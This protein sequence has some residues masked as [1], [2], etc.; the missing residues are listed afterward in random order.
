MLRVRSHRSDCARSLGASERTPAQ[1]TTRRR[2]AHPMRKTPTTAMRCPWRITE[3]PPSLY[4]RLLLRT[5]RSMPHDEARRISTE[6]YSPKCLEGE[7][8][9]VREQV[10]LLNPFLMSTIKEGTTLR[11]AP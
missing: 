6:A 9:E 5:P 11:E 10:D 1:P 4:M 7:F 3:H 2:T 8:S